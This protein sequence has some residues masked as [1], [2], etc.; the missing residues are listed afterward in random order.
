M[1]DINDL[2]HEIADGLLL[3]FGNSKLEF[4]RVYNSNLK[5]NWKL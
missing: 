3:N 5:D 2:T 4:N 1:K